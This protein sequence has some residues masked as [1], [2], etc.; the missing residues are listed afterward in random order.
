[1]H[2]YHDGFMNLFVYADPP[3]TLFHQEVCFGL[4]L[5]YVRNF[6]WD[7]MVK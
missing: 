4:M 3:T 1:M 6:H 2:N 5:V 7:A